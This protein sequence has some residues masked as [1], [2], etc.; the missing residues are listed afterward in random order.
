MDNQ[1]PMSFL[2]AKHWSMTGSPLA[3]I[4]GWVTIDSDF[5]TF[6]SLPTASSAIFPE[7]VLGCLRDCSGGSEELSAA[8]WE[9]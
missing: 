5:S 3:Y 6:V 4:H 8:D 7:A 1:L 2:S 9:S